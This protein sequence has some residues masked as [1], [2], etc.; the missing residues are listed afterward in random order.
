MIGRRFGRLEIVAEPVRRHT[1][2]YVA[3]KCRCNSDVER[4]YP[5]QD[6]LKIKVRSC[7][8]LAAEVN[9]LLNSTDSEGQPKYSTHREYRTWQSLIQKTTNVR[10]PA[11]A[12]NGGRGIQV[13]EQWRFDF[14]K[15]FGDVGP[16]PIGHNLVRVDPTGGFEPGNVRWS[17]SRRGP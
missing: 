11:Y 14:P 6:L 13:C 3:A 2:R 9:Y 4:Y 15:F 16:A 7:G 12:Q 5:L 17:P 10:S 1:G 8:C